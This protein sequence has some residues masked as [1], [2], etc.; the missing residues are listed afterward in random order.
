MQTVAPDLGRR[1]AE[2]NA[3]FLVALAV[4]VFLA[5]GTLAYW[6]GWLFVAHFAAWAAG[7]SIY[8][9]YRD[10]ALLEKRM[11]G[12]PAAETE[13]VQKRIQIFTSI[14]MVALIIVSVLDYRFHWSAVPLWAV[15]AGNLLIA[16][17]FLF[18]V[19]VLRENTFASATIEVSEGQK[20]VSTGPYA[21]VRHPMYA[22]VL[23]LASGIPLALASVWGLLFVPLIFAGLILRLLDEEGQLRRNLPGYEDYCLKVRYR[24]FPGIW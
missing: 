12:G 17:G 21:F 4:M 10:P 19:I 11:R 9:Y 20:V 1:A 18:V 14:V 15:I 13:P 8:F 24:L 6:Q 16:A 7:T 2:A 23:P 22:G 5:A 3:K